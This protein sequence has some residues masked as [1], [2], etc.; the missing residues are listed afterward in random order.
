MADDGDAAPGVS[1]GAR[2][3]DGRV[4][5][6]QRTRILDAM[7][8]VVA[9][10]GFAGASVGA[11]IARAKVSRRTFY[12]RFASFED[13]FL[14]ILDLA[15]ERTG[16]LILQA[17]QREDSWTDGIRAALA[18]LLQF[19]EAE[20]QLARVWLVESLAAGAWALERRER[21]L[22]ELRAAIVSWWSGPE[23]TVSGLPAPVAAEG[24]MASLLGVIQGHMV[25]AG[26]RAPLIELLGPLA[27]LAVG[28]F[29]A[30]E[31][32]AE[33]VR[34]GA[35]LAGAIQADREARRASRPDS[36]ARGG[37]PQ[38]EGS[39]REEDSLRGEDSP[40]AYE[41]DRGLSVVEIPA[42]L[43]NTKAGRARECMLFLAEQ[44]G[45]GP[46]SSSAERSGSGPGPSNMEIAAAIGIAHKGQMSKLLA[47]L[48][49][50]GLLSK[51]SYG[52]GR[53]NAWKLTPYGEE[54]ARALMG[55]I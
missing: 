49:S 45:S 22:A 40:Q 24:V 3:S 21:N 5:Q 51:T 28:P 32:V 44:G 7:V 47:R 15:G 16:T 17:F 34:R 13:C 55:P 31:Q 9:E 8:Q 30:P 12:E 2:S 10:R 38:A 18:S 48:G 23:L 52:P 53:P 1:W 6:I 25:S 26:E 39:L 29:L 41:L 37:S 46:G 20:P 33:E 19:F 50:Y 4:A 27:G 43:H 42:M 11:V 54:V 35:E 36:P 14:A